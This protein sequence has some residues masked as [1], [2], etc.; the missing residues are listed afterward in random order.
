MTNPALSASVRPEGLPA[1][2]VE[3]VERLPGEAVLIPPED[4]RPRPRDG[5][6]GLMI[7]ESTLELMMLGFTIGEHPCGRRLDATEDAE[8]ALDL[9]T[10]DRYDFALLLLP[11]T[12]MAPLEFALRLRERQTGEKQAPFL[13]LVGD[14]FH[15][16]LRD[17]CVESGAVAA[18]L[19]TPVTGER[20]KVLMDLLFL[21]G[22]TPPPA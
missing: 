8:M 1:F 17:G 21:P 6:R 9:L 11:T 10:A 7:G 4:R 22:C 15:R 18:R 12:R 20:L 19:R 2:S 3:R 14:R 5:I 13:V 16:D